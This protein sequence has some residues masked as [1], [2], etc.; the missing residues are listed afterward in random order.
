MKE[1]TLQAGKDPLNW[2]LEKGVVEGWYPVGYGKQPLYELEIALLDMVRRRRIVRCSTDDMQ[3]GK[4]LAKSQTRVAFRHAEVVQEKLDGQDGT[5]FLFEVNGVRIFCGGSNWIPA[6]SFLTEIKPERYRKWVE[7]L[8]GSPRLGQE[9]GLIEPG[10]GEPEYAESLGRRD[11]R[12][13]SAIQVSRYIA[14][15]SVVEGV[16]LSI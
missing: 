12:G 9:I 6:D 16:S 15:T 4:E 13:R 7:M 11:L 8:V 14:E 5:T 3:S 1:S 10:C 2:T